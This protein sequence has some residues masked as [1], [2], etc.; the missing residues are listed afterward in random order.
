MSDL[1][2]YDDGESYANVVEIDPLQVAIRLH[3]LAARL[4]ELAGGDPV[5][6]WELIAD[7]REI[8]LSIG[9]AVTAHFLAR[10]SISAGDL[11][12][13]IHDVRRWV[14]AENGESI[15]AWEG[16]GLDLRRISIAIAREIIDWLK[17]EGP[18]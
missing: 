17:R 1:P 9:Q 3:E 2:T 12:R 7:E 14:A 10:R 11:A 18:R 15:P 16:L 4:H 8:G 5:E 6:W 13:F